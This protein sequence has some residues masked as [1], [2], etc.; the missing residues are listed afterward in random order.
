MYS[1][2]QSDFSPSKKTARIPVNQFL[3]TGINDLLTR[4]KMAEKHARLP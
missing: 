4:D 3:I 2:I 1:S